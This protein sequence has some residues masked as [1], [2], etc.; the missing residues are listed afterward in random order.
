MDALKQYK[1]SLLVVAV[2][3]AVL[4]YVAPRLAATAPAL[5]APSGKFG[6]AG[7]LVL[8]VMTGGIHRVADACL[9]G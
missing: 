2:M 6:P 3:F 1:T 7:L 5:L 8:A 4:W 9:G